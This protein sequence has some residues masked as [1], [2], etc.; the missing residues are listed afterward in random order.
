MKDGCW[1]SEARIAL[2]A[3]LSLWWQSTRMARPSVSKG[4]VIDSS[5]SSSG[6]VNL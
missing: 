3:Y 1:T 2:A 4:S 5:F 6:K